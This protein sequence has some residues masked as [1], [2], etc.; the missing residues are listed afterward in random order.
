MSS[1]FSAT[2]SAVSSAI[3]SLNLPRTS[4]NK[5]EF[6]FYIDDDK[7]PYKVFKGD[8]ELPKKDRQSTLQG[9]ERGADVTVKH[10]VEKKRFILT[11]VKLP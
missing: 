9:L 3:S 2:P 4:V 5:H 11:E 6:W 1:P 8:K 10:N 7:F